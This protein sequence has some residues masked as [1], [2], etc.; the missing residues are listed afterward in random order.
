M[1]ILGFQAAF[2]LMGAQA[3][4]RAALPDNGWLSPISNGLDYSLHQIQ[5]GL[6]ALHV[7][8]SYG[9]AIVCLTVGTK[10]LTFP[11]TK[12]QVRWLA[13]LQHPLAAYFRVGEDEGSCPV[14]CSGV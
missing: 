9:W 10:L 14:H 1:A 7:P 12:I 5:G 4:R 8:Y 2:V 13:T 11:F 6:D 3:A